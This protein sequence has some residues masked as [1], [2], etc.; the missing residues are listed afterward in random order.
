MKRESDGGVFEIKFPV[1]AD[2]IAAVLDWMRAVLRP[3]PHGTGEHGDS[4]LVQSVY[5]DTPDFDVFHKRG[6]YGRA[7]FRIRRYGSDPSIFLERKLK[8][9]GVVRKRRVPIQAG[10]LGGLNA[11]ANGQVWAG[12]WFHHRLAL[13]RL[14]PVVRMTYRRVARFG[15]GPE[16]RFRVTL[17]RDVR[18]EKLEVIQAPQPF[19]S[20]DLLGGGALLEVKFKETLPAEVKRLLEAT[21][22]S[23]G[24]FSK[25]RL[26]VKSCGLAVEE[27]T[28]AAA[29][30]PV[31]ESEN[32]PSATGPLALGGRM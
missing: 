5:L 10:E 8:R 4:Y 16:G 32:A 27:S 21:G 3:D 2:R 31:P 29:T 23:A 9:T 11:E 19:E 6:S 22:L 12:S 26:G 1:P 14:R 13:R 30:V 24:P 7:K 17:D 15:D 28:E 18:A 20:D 25:Y